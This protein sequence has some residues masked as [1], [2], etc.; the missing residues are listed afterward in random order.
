MKEGRDES[1]GVLRRGLEQGDGGEGGSEVAEWW[2]TTKGEGNQNESSQSEME[3]E[4][5]VQWGWDEAEARAETWL[6][7][8]KSLFFMENATKTKLESLNQV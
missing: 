4:R 3:V 7:F 2:A 8:I 5:R 6:L 1:H